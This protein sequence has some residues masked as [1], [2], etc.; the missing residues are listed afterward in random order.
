MASRACHAL[1]CLGQKDGSHLLHRHIDAE[2]RWKPRTGKARKSV[3]KARKSEL[4]VP[5]P[6]LLASSQL[7]LIVQTSDPAR[8]LKVSEE[9]CLASEDIQQILSIS[10]VE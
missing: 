8:R 9:D 7:R 2:G 5:R 3:G 6:I 1:H 10:V 4:I